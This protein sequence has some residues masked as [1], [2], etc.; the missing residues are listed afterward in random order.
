M[1]D[2]AISDPAAVDTKKADYKHTL[3]LPTTDFAMKADLAKREPETLAR[4]DSI[5]LYQAIL[6]KNRGRPEFRLHDGPPYANGTIHHG[7]MLNKIL[8]D[9]TI[10]YRAMSGSY[11]EY[12]PG[13]DCHGL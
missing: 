4:W 1:N 9:I 12:V 3:R 7:H 11:V 2:K 10:K 13:W 6:D 8:K 5:H